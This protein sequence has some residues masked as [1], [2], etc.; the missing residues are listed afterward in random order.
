MEPQELPPPVV[1]KE[2]PDHLF[3]VEMLRD[4]K[5][6]IK[7]VT[8]NG[9]VSSLALRVRSLLGGPGWRNPG[10]AEIVRAVHNWPS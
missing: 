4:L 5:S 1:F 10:Q 9:L 7:Q 3:T 2:T 6:D 8:V